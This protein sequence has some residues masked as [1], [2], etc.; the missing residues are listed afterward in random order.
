MANTI[1]GL[2][3]KRNTWPYADKWEGIG[4]EKIAE[5]MSKTLLYFV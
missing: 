1:F 3:C 2:L 4:A 5:N